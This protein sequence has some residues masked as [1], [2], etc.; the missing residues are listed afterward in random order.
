MSDTVACNALRSRLEFSV[1][2]FDARDVGIQCAGALHEHRVRGLRFGGAP[3]QRL[4]RFARIAKPMLRARELLVGGALLVVEPRDRLA[5]F[6]LPRLETL[7]LL[8]GAS[9]LDLEQ[10]EFLLHLLQVVGRTLQL[11]VETDHR[12]LLAMQVCVHRCNRVRHLSDAGFERR[13]V[14]HRL[15]AF[16]LFAGYAIA[17][18]LDLALDAENGAPFVFAA[19]GARAS[20]RAPRR[21][22]ASQ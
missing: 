13:D 8:F 22:S 20:G 18:F 11:H 7:A 14:R 10:F 19:A 2:F 16:G 17:Q 3:G 5:R 4:Q 21:R 6:A 1:G 15:I 12:L 9:P